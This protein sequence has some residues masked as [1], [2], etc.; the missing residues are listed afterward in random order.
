MRVALLE[1]DSSYPNLALM[2]AAAWHR[3]RGDSVEWYNVFDEYDRLYMSK[4]FTFTP[5][6]YHPITNVRG[7]ILRGGTGYDVTTRLPPEIDRMQPDYSI[8][9]QIDRRTSYGFLTRGCVRKCPWCVVPLKEG[10]V[11]PYN[12]IDEITQGGERPNA[13]LMDNNILAAG[14]YGREQLRKI[15]RR[16]YRVDFNQGLDARLVDDEAAAM[17]ARIRWQSYIR[18]GCD[19]PGQ[20]KDCERAIA[21]IRAKGYRGRF[22]LYCIIQDLQESYERISHWR[23]DPKITPYGQPYRDPRGKGKAVPQWQKDMAQW[24]DRKELYFKIDFKE[25]RPRKGFQ[26]AEYFQT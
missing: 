26:C 13:V 25:F 16:R 15:I 2:K 4:V 12:D 5:D 20:I 24:A 11:T 14:E 3:Q 10:G 1:V 18:F 9:P 19:T 8:Y 7:E 6:W 21:L 23:G 22:F 17:L